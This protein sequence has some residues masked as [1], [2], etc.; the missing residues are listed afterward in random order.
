PRLVSFLANVATT[1]E[2]PYQFRRTAGGGTD[3]GAIHLSRSG[4]PAAGIS[5]ACRYIH[6]PA[7]ICSKSDLENTSLLVQHTLQA[8]NP[9]ILNR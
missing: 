8:I 6:A 3:A 9:D 4:V 1:N 7:S 5:V 2:I